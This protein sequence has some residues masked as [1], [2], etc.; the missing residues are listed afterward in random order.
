MTNGISFEIEHKGA[1]FTVYT[2]GS[3][4]TG[5][6]SIRGERFAVNY[7]GA[8]STSCLSASSYRRTP[9]WIGDHARKIGAEVAA[10]LPRE[11]HDANRAMYATP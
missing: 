10:M 3:G 11:W 9:K 8:V 1:R 7:A 4:F 2:D 5:I 6:V